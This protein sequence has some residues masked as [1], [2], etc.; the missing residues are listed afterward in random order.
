[1]SVLLL[2]NKE[3]FRSISENKWK[4]FLDVFSYSVVWV[5]I[6]PKP[7]GEAT[8]PFQTTL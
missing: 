2:Y 1:M 3:L 5:G 4:L 6:V 7:V 8:I